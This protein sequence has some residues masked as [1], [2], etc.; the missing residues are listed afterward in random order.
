MWFFLPS[1]LANCKLTIHSSEIRG[2]RST[3]CSSETLQ[4]L[5]YF[6]YKK[7]HV[8]FFVFHF[9]QLYIFTLWLPWSVS[10]VD[11]DQVYMPFCQVFWMPSAI[12]NWPKFA[13]GKRHAVGNRV[14]PQFAL[15]MS[16]KKPISIFFCIPK[17]NNY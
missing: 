1:I 15:Y 4:N 9:V 14:K 16:C 12:G 2:L 13:V 6:M 5:L 8:V 17:Q 10:T 3:K 7:T 11:I